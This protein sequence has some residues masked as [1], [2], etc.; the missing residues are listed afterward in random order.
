MV[1][2]ADLLNLGKKRRSHNGARYLYV[3]GDHV[4]AT[5]EL[6]H[7]IHDVMASTL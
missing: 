7:D 5:R 1:R 3:G 2:A 6:P 4:A